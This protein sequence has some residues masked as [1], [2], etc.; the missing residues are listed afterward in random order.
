MLP[1]TKPPIWALRFFYWFCHPDLQEE[2]VGDLEENFYYN[3]EERGHAFANR[4]FYCEVLL[5]FRPSVIKPLRFPNFFK[6]SPDMLKHYFKVALRN[7][8]RQKSYSLINISGMAIGLAIVMLIALFVRKELSYDTFHEKA[9]SIYRLTH[10][11]SF[12]HGPWG[13]TM[14]ADYPEVLDASRVSWTGKLK[15]RLEDGQTFFENFHLAEPN[16]FDFFTY[17]FIEGDKNT[18]LDQPDALVLT[19]SIAIKY[20][21]TTKALGKTVRVRNMAGHD[22]LLL[23]VTGVMEDV[24][25]NSHV[26]FD[27]LAS[28]QLVKTGSWS[29]L[30]DDWYQDWVITY[31]LLDKNADYRALNDKMPAFF[32]RHTGEV[33]GRVTESLQP[34]LDIRLHSSHLRRDVEVQGDI[35]HVRIFA[36]TAILILIIACFNFMNLATARAVRRAKEV[37]IRKVVGA[38][39]RQLLW[40]FLGESFLLTMIS[41][42]LALGITKLILPYF[43]DFLAISIQPLPGDFGWILSSLLGLTVVVSLLAGG[44]PALILSQFRPM[45][46]LKT[47]MDG[48]K[49]STLFRKGLVVMQFGISTIL[50]IGTIVVF[51]QMKYMKNKSLGYDIE[52][53]LFMNYGQGMMEDFDKVKGALEQNP[54]VLSIANTTDIMGT[55]AYM[56]RF[57]FDGEHEQPHGDNLPQFMVGENFIETLDIEILEGRSFRKGYAPDTAGFILNESMV[58]DAIARFGEKWR[59]PIGLNLDFLVTRDGEWQVQK[60]GPVIGVVKNFHFRSL[61]H[62]IQPLIIHYQPDWGGRIVLRISPQDIPGTLAF[63]EEKWQEW[64]RERPFHYQFLDER[65]DENY[66]AEENFSSILFAFC[67][68][69]VFIACLGLFG[70]ASF[71]AEQYVKEIGIRKILGASWLDITG[72]FLRAFLQPVVLAF[73]LAIPIG[74]LAMNKWLENFAYRINIDA[75]TF[76]FAGIL[77][78][79]IALITISYR[80]LSAAKRNPV[81]ALRYE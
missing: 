63:L 58:A 64:G 30:L 72:I 42:L 77:A 28:F 17:S 40:Q 29:S 14:V 24:P 26:H 19:E 51:K 48:G 81:E 43:Q 18:A 46:T 9:D 49:N 56:W 70:L 68:L 34:L 8:V 36:A 35:N 16:F 7:L 45:Y 38:L 6:I 4:E 80:T 50:I 15:T 22:S 55:V 61:Q 66:Q 44:Y 47:K 79:L 57:R 76:V 59:N 71:T 23:K 53:V 3:L 13:P 10:I 11:Y 20:F 74:Y 12:V 37:G 25:E 60:S 39:R 31:L 62:A 21:G 69:A 33:G 52:Q 67:I 41:V 54:N 65:F 5:L 32:E 78:I 75:S 1:N 27:Q 73:F 2:L